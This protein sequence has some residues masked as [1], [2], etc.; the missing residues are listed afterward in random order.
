[1]LVGANILNILETLKYGFHHGILCGYFFPR[2]SMVFKVF[3]VKLSGVTWFI[4]VWGF[5]RTT[6]KLKLSIMFRLESCNWGILAKWTLKWKDALARGNC[7]LRIQDWHKNA[8]FH[9]FH[10]M[11]VSH[12]KVEHL[13]HLDP[14]CTVCALSSEH[15]EHHHPQNIVI[16]IPSTW[17]P[18]KQYSWTTWE[19]AGLPYWVW[20][21]WA[22][23]LQLELYLVRKVELWRI[24]RAE[25]SWWREGRGAAVHVWVCVCAF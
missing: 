12:L 4:L 1:M 22:Q 15:W 23:S 25:C 16:T 6:N 18:C 14:R 13:W 19:K 20:K 9:K 3:K 24:N 17:V 8:L 10:C 7:P 5:E 2:V 11:Q 21:S